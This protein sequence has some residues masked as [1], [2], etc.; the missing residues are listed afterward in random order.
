MLSGNDYAW[1]ATSTSDVPQFSTE[2][3]ALSNAVAAQPKLAVAKFPDVRTPALRD[4]WARLQD[5]VDGF[6]TQIVLLDND[7]R[8]VIVNRT[9]RMTSIMQ[10]LNSA[11][12]A[13]GQNY[14]T[15]CHRSAAQGCRDAARAAEGIG[16]VLEGRWRSFFYK[17]SSQ[18]E[19]ERR[20]YGMTAWRVIEDGRPYVAVM[21][22]LLETR[23][24]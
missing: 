18:C 5:A 1:S 4:H 6:E 19:K 10:G 22:E 17:Y 11:Q 9:W 8:I 20:L 14:L 24:W 21:H 7:G 12:H 15:I 16:A 13:V 3:V 23:P 2:G